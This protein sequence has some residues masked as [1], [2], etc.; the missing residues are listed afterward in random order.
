[1]KRLFILIVAA[2]MTVS[3]MAEGHMKFKGIEMDGQLGPFVA[4]LQQQ[5][6]SVE[7]QSDD[8][9]MLSGIFNGQEA[10]VYAYASARSHTVYQVAVV[11][12]HSGK[13]WS[14]IWNSY[15]TYQERLE[16]KYGEPTDYIEENRCSFSQNDPLFSLRTDQAEYWTL[17]KADYGSILLSIKNLSFPFDVHV[18]ITYVDAANW[19]LNEN[20]VLEDL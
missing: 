14:T 8:V 19:G 1:M 17:Y 3:V 10:Y 16:K 18:C 4:A 6:F 15:T 5:K 7:E 2:M 20:E 11:F 12:V 9:A 13:E